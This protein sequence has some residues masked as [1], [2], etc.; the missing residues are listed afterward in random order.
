MMLALMVFE[1][2]YTAW[3]PMHAVS[4]LKIPLN[5]MSHD[6]SNPVAGDTSGGETSVLD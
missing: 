5:K 4:V 2:D 3:S 6:G 1:W